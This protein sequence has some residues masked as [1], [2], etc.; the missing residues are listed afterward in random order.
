MGVTQYLYRPMRG[1]CLSSVVGLVLLAGCRHVTAPPVAAPHHPAAPHPPLVAPASLP[2]AIPRVTPVLLVKPTSSISSVTDRRYAEKIASRLGDWI[3]DCGIPV[4][5][6]TDD[7]LAQ[8][9]WRK[10]RVVVLPCNLRPGAAELAALHQFTAGGGKVVVFFSAEPKLAALLG[11]KLGVPVKAPSTQPWREFK[12]GNGAPEGTPSCVRQDST[13]LRPI[14]PAASDA[15]VIAWWDA[16][17]GSPRVPAWVA[18]PHGYW[19]SHVLLE[20]DIA[21]K[22]QLLTS[23]L[24]ACDGALWKVAAA[25]AYNQAGTLDR[26]ASASQAI[27]ALGASARTDRRVDELLDEA[28]SLRAKLTQAYVAADYPRAVTT[29]GHLDEVITEAYARTRVGRDGEFRG[30]WNHSGVGFEPGQWNSTCGALAKAGITDL[31]PNLQRPWCAHYPSK[32]IPASDV[33]TRHGD[34]AAACLAAAR[35]SGLHVHAW[36]IL[37]NLEGAPESVIAPY[38][39]AGRTQVTATGGNVD[40]LCPSHPKNRAFELAAVLDLLKRYPK[41]DGIHLDY[42]RLKSKDTCYC[43]GC[44]T[45]FTQ[46]TGLKPAK[47]PADARSGQLAG[48]YR[49]WRA[50]LITRFVAEVHREIHK[51]DPKVKLSASVYP[52]YPGTRDS[53][54][55]DW[56]EWLRTG[57]MEFACPM[58]YTDSPV[59]FSD[60]YRRQAAY[61][62]VKGKLYPGIGVTSLE[63][64]LSVAQVLSQ[65]TVLRTE[66]A[67]GFMLFEANTTVRD[68]VL[69]VLEMGKGR[70]ERNQPQNVE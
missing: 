2:V 20:G 66:G 39:R 60:W 37:W 69:P 26:Y 17:R 62:G 33:L 36:V 44:R 43:G 25:R 40:W 46:A 65:L 28:C 32:L 67:G 63:A 7:Q 59:Q 5:T 8:G 14:H 52:L 29:A 48:A 49:K 35:E 10:A 12:F 38:R 30:I 27:A 24:G 23:L 21:A 42:I 70:T 6:V 64:R 19:M 54:A 16:Q 13:Q 1:I 58:N 34:Q 9:A 3:D 45:R 57:I 41:L 22:K 15:R 4:S 61:P 50:E 18:S 11:F 53:I 55:Q 31:F 47:W 68:D 56:G 51:I